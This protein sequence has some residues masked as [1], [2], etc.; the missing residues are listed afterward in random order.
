MRLR[1]V[2]LIARDLEP[3][4]EQVRRVFG[5]TVCLD[6]AREVEL[7][8]DDAVAEFGI[9]NAVFAVGDTFLEVISPT[10][11]GTTA[12]RYLLGRGDSGYM[13]LLQGTDLAADRRRAARLGIREVWE[14]PLPAI[15]GV[16]F[17]PRDT[18][19]SL[20]SIDQPDDPQDWPWAGPDWRDAVRTDVISDIVGVEVQTADPAAVA[21]RW[22]ELLA[23]PTRPGPAD[24]AEVVLER[25]RIRFVRLDERC[26]S[27]EGVCGVEV[28][29]P[30]AD[31][32]RRRARRQGL[33]VDGN[34]RIILCG[35]AF[36]P[37]AA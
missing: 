30:D 4:V 19:G 10:R 35:V 25:G 5:L 1:Q 3:I 21:A 18:R 37:M 14:S 8:G 15:Q 13:V 17:D 26:N 12:A 31:E 23:M 33:P 22:G 34:G 24:T 20:L 16:H 36:T 2:A 11:N 7:W 27:R 9:A 6:V 28:R 29:C 32:V